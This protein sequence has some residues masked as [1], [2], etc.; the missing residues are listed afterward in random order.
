MSYKTGLKALLILS[1]LVI[2]DKTRASVY[3]SENSEASKQ[4]N[5]DKPSGCLRS[6]KT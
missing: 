1:K 6:F 2:A 3:S 5:H 4:V